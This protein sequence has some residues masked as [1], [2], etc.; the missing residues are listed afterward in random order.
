MALKYCTLQKKFNKSNDIDQVLL[1]KRRKDVHDKAREIADTMIPQ[2][3]IVMKD[4]REQISSL[5]KNYI[6]VF[7]NL[8]KK[9]E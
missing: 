8:S 7:K 6:I 5:V 4:I 1:G 3:Q 9:V 2:I